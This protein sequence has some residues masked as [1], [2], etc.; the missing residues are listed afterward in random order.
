MKDIRD[1]EFSSKIARVALLFAFT[2]AL[3]AARTPVHAGRLRA[4]P[5]GERTT[6]HDLSAYL[7]EP[8]SNYEHGV[9][10]DVVEARGFV[11]ERGKQTLVVR[12]PFGPVFEDRRV[13]LADL[14][15]DGYPEAILVKSYPDRGS[16]LAAYRIL[17]HAIVPIAE[18]SAIGRRHRWL[19]PVGIGDFQGTGEIMIAAVT[20]PHVDGS[21]RL[22]RL[23]G[24]TL[25]PA[26]RING[27]TNHIRGSGDLD[28]GRAVDLDG[29]GALEVVLPTMDRLSLAVISFKGGASV[30]KKIAV[31]SPI[32]TLE[33]IDTKFA[34]VRTENGRLKLDLR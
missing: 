4:L 14:D 17:P 28:L 33:S 29:D 34:V 9:L 5:G 8:T 24:H 12:L 1:R 3:V 22:Y 27:F 30:R 31:A 15:G 2:I 10:G 13:R 32:V 25:E 23:A 11:V 21:L 20:T 19:N 18:S 6:S 16:A 7:I 26:A